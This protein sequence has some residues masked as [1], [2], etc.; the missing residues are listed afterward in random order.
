MRGPEL[1]ARL[2]AE[3]GSGMRS[4]YISG[5]ADADVDGPLLA[6]PF[7]LDQLK[8]VLHTLEKGG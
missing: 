3:R 7:D 4:L 1:G 8:R 5:F 2:S 6:K